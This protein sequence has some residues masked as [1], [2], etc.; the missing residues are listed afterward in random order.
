MRRTK[1]FSVVEEG[2]EETDFSRDDVKKILVT[3]VS[4]SIILLLCI[5]Y[6]S[7]HDACL[8]SSLLHERL[9]FLLSDA[10]DVVLLVTLE[11]TYTPTATPPSLRSKEEKE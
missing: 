10:T 6:S 11:L 5:L 2:F 4:S 8:S 9:I 7:F 1:S 3:D